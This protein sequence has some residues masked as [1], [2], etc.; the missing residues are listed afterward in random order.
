MKMITV[1]IVTVVLLTLGLCIGYTVLTDG[2]S[3][4]W[5]WLGDIL[6]MRDRT[7]T[8]EDGLTLLMVM[9]TS[10]VATSIITLRILMRMGGFCE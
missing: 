8:V 4:T 3:E 10:M 7:L 2:L 1:S 5:Y 9:L 6:A